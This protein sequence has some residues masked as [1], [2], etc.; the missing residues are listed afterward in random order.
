MDAP[1]QTICQERRRLSKYYH[2]AG[3]TQEHFSYQYLR[4]R[5]LVLRVCWNGNQVRW[6][7]I[8]RYSKFKRKVQIVSTLE[9][10]VECPLSPLL[11]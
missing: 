6:L 4:Y 5:H 9:I 8:I 11:S 10:Q 3:D 2:K 1:Y 7:Q